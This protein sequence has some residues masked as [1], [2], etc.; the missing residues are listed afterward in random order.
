MPEIGN[1]V[2]IIG[3][4]GSWK[5]IL[6]EKP[7]P[8]KGVGMGYTHGAEGVDYLAL[9]K[10]M[11]A[12]TVR[13]WGERHGTK[14]YLDLAFERGLY[15]NAGIWL[16]HVFEDGVCS[17]LTDNDCTRD[18]RIDVINYVKKYKNHPAI[19]FWN[20]G[21]ETI[22]FTESEEERI[23][24]SRFLE[25]LIKEVKLIDPNHPVVYTSAYTTAIDYI[26]RYVPSLDIIG[27]NVYG[28]LDKAHRQVKE[29]LNI[30][31]LV[32]EYG[33]QGPWDQFNDI[34][35]KPIDQSD[36]D[37]AVLYQRHTKFIQEAQGYCLG[38]YVFYLGESTQ[39][40][41]TWWNLTLKEHKRL[42]FVLMQQAYKNETITDRPPF[43][44]EITLNPQQGLAPGQMFDI[45][46]DMLK[47]DNEGVRFRYYA[48]TDNE[49]TDLDEFP[50]KEVALLI[51][52]VGATVK[53]RAPEEEGIYRIYAVALGE[54]DLVDTLSSTISVRK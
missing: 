48:S 6:N 2:K 5:V 43:I 14:A 29:K 44:R 38:G 45:H 41:L 28:G 32:S 16:N 30:P 31:Y 53:A 25:E 33:P 17:Y 40:S 4:K 21:N 54:N 50:N 11:G 23:A 39:V 3:E 35:G 49:H 9:A 19:L 22:H 10:E 18:A 12:N 26:E 1:V 15:V 42:S 46:V 34:N 8:L 37:K 20:I 13:T 52:G 27:I 7:F 47:K 24:F 36:I 51:E